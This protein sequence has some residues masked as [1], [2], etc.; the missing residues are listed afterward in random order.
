MKLKA[1]KFDKPPDFPG[2]P[3]RSG[4]LVECDN[5]PEV[6]YGFRCVVRGG[7]VFLISPPGWRNGTG[8]GRL[9][10]GTW[11]VGDD[12][13]APRVAF[14]TPRA[15]VQLMWGFESGEDPH[16]EIAEFAK[17]GFY[18]S[19]PF[20]KA[21]PTEQNSLLAQIPVKEE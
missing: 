21:R 19:D 20:D 6:M 7:S 2:L 10:S 11:Q 14:E 17:R 9:V 12:P 4:R 5:P 3:L 8:G 15:E 16:R 13:R 18:E 1:I